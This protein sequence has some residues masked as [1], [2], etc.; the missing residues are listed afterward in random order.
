MKRGGN[1][2]YLGMSYGFFFMDYGY[3]MNGLWTLAE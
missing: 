2:V 3:L 1:E